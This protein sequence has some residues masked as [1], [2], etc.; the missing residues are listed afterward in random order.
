MEMFEMKLSHTNCAL[1]FFEASYH[2]VV[3][4]TAQFGEDKFG[5]KDAK[6]LRKIIIFFI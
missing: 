5:K 3:I 1:T 6:T 2:Q 4:I